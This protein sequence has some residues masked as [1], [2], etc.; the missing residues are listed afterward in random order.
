[1]SGRMGSFAQYLIAAIA[2]VAVGSAWTWSGFANPFPASTFFLLTALTA[3]FFGFGP[4]LVCTLASALTFTSMVVWELTFPPHVQVMRVGMFV[5]ASLV[6]ASVSR[7]RSRDVREAEE[8]LHALFETSL[9]AI[10]FVRRDGT[11]IDANPAASVLLGYSREELLQHRAGDFSLADDR[12]KRSEL[13]AQ[14]E[15]EGTA[16]GDAVVV[17]K[18]GS[19]REVEYRAVG[20]ALPGVH[21]V[22][23]RD[24]TERKDAERALRQLSG[25][26]LHLQDEERRRI[27][28]QLHDTTAQSLAAISLNLSRISRESGA[29]SG[30]IREAVDES[31]ELTQQSIAEVRTLS[32]LLHPPMID[33]GGLLPSLRWF[34]RGFEQRS[35]I[36][37]TLEAPAEIGRLPAEV[38]TA[39]FRI[40]QEALTNIH[41]HSGSAVAGIR[42]ERNPGDI[43]LEVRDEG[44]G[45]RKEL[46][47]HP[48]ALLAAGVGIAGIRERVRELEGETEIESGDGGMRVV[49][50]L[51]I[52]NSAS[53]QNNT[54]GNGSHPAG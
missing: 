19:T 18:D 46:R 38:E 37:S 24:I 21:F 14:V 28:R 44:R 15:V 33:E 49:V 16:S 41:R 42:L 53:P 26:L 47:E 30:P 34:V 8:R 32:Y 52:R 51:P 40:V 12:H 22:I 23:M 9:D 54:N 4:A 10:L 25:R 36:R 5:F 1:M 27:A 39:V 11:Y 20:N 29:T 6:V 7:Q 45:M 17:R 31:M 2:P 48:N 35:G 13:I 3:R 43:R 50:T